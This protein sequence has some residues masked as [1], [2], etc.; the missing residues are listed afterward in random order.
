[1]KLYKNILVPFDLTQQSTR[2]VKVA[3]D[4]AKTRNSKV[5]L[6][7]CLEGDAWHHK[8]YDAR[9]DTQLIKQQKKVA[10]KYLEKLEP[11]AKRYGI[12]VKSRILPSKNVVRDIVT[13]AK[14]GKYDLV[15]IGS[16]GK[17]GFDKWLL[18]SV[19]NGVSQKVHCTVMIVK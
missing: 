7:T 9:I 16:H 6:L 11:T 14:K 18:G 17:S 12:S 5:T 2:A 8:Y 15:V 19:A 13:F 3:F 1:M 4:I 10:K